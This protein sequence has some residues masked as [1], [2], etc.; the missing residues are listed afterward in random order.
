[1]SVRLSPAGIE[2]RSLSAST[3]VAATTAPAEPRLQ[4]PQAAAEGDPEPGWYAGFAARQSR[5]NEEVTGAQRALAWL[6]VLQSRLRELARRLRVDPGAGDSAPPAISDALAGLCEAW[7][8]R[9]AAT[10]G[11][12]DANLAWC[13]A[14]DARQLFRLRG[15]DAVALAAAE[16]ETL[17]F[18]PRGMGRPS[19][20]LSLLAGEAPAPRW[21]R[22]AEVMA[23]AGIDV[24][25]S[26]GELRLSVLESAWPLLREQLLVQ[27]GGRRFPSGWPGR[28][29]LEPIA[30]PIACEQWKVDTRQERQQVFRQV[31]TLLIQ[32]EHT[33][34]VLSSVLGEGLQ[35]LHGGD[36]APDP[37]AMQA[38]ARDF[39]AILDRPGNFLRLAT[40]GACLRGISRR[41][42]GAVLGS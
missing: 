6:D 30:G 34:A 18:H 13:P 27:G 10:G 19:R 15:L 21:Q 11:T 3:G 31:S 24:L 39:A 12:L 4:G 35:V 17:V 32:I 42:V 23:A 36:E 5:L 16:P 29:V 14:G 37:A 9:H 22:L 33:R 2:R 20:T 1:M 41:K 38:T 25:D 7:L 8:R 26:D 28:A 40:A